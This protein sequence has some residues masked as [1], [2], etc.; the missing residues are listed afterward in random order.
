MT[1]DYCM[2]WAKRINNHA[3][4]CGRTDPITEHGQAI[5]VLSDEVGRLR[6][7]VAVADRLME[8]MEQSRSAT[9]SEFDRLQADNEVLRA[10]LAQAR[11]ERDGYRR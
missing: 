8:L 11:P 2:E 4:I 5:S 9:I 6:E 10:S 1:V 3:F 7:R